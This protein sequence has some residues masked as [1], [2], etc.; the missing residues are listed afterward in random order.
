M[1]KLKGQRK[2]L[3]LFYCP[4]PMATAFFFSPAPVK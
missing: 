3:A 2:G 4:A 1:C